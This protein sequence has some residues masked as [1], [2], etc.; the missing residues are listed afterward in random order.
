MPAIRLKTD[1]GQRFC[2][3]HLERVDGFGLSVLVLPKAWC[4]TKISAVMLHSDG[5]HSATVVMH[6]GDEVCI[7]VDS[8]AIAGELVSRSQRSRS[9]VRDVVI[10]EAA[11]G[12]RDSDTFEVDADSKRRL[13]VRVELAQERE[14]T[15]PVRTA[16]DTHD[17]LADG[18]LA[19]LEM[20]HRL[21]DVTRVDHDLD[22]SE[23]WGALVDTQGRDMDDALLLLAQWRFV[24]GMER[25]LRRIRRGY[26]PT[27]GREPVIRGRITQRGL[28]QA[29]MGEL[30][31]ECAYDEFVETTPLYRILVTALDHVAMGAM[32]TRHGLTGWSLHK[33]VQA[34]AIRLRR[35]LA[36]IP[37]LPF[38]VAAQR[39]GQLRLPALHR[40][41]QPLLD[42][43]RALLRDDAPRGGA[44]RGTACSFQWRIS[45]AH[46]WEAWLRAAAEGA[47]VLDGSKLAVASE[48][49]RH[50]PWEELGSGKR[51]DLV[52]QNATTGARA[53][54][55]AKY[56]R[57]P[58]LPSPADQYQVW[59]YSLAYKNV[60]AAALVYPAMGD[61]DG[62]SVPAMKEFKRAKPAAWPTEAVW[63]DV[64]L[65]VLVLPFPPR[66]GGGD[67]EWS[68]Q[69]GTVRRALIELMEREGVR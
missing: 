20:S 50:K 9:A 48:P 6:E 17:A 25:Q 64:R 27:V 13:L 45:T 69:L 11:L 43:A 58:S 42:L 3:L 23:H 65:R 53:V 22:A 46:I 10:A 32:A 24:Q 36:P 40:D 63:A 15:K 68:E 8:S 54:I 57:P 56:K 41:W 31:I 44:P 14:A 66:L 18:M 59:F 29:G 1:E 62:K 61:G 7:R 49:S 37:S 67:A 4:G 52:L 38:A 16:D 33:E 26:V 5:A 12:E 39:A 35:Q 55:D 2:G 28:V 34:T 51:V 21:R 19:L 47:S 30:A 60:T